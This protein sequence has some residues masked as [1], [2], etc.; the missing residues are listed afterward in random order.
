[1]R[2][3]LCIAALVVAVLA[4]ALPTHAGVRDLLKRG[5]KKEQEQIL[6]CIQRGAW[7]AYF[8]DDKG[9]LA[10]LRDTLNTAND[11]E[12]IGLR[13]T[14][15]EGPRIRLGVLKVINKSA[16]SEERGYAD[17]IEVPVAG[18]QE[19]LTAALYNTKRFDVIEQKRVEEILKQQTR[20][21]V[22]EPSP[23]AIVNVGKVLGA[24]YLVYGTVNEWNPGRGSTNLGKNLFQRGVVKAGKNDAE[25]A[26]TFTLTDVANGQN[27]FTTTERARMGEWSFGFGGLGGGEGA[28]QQTTPV[29][30]AIRACTNKAAFKIATFL[31]DRKWKGTVVDIKKAEI[32]VNAGSQQGMAPQSKLLVQTV[33]G[34]VKDHESGTI[35]GEDLKGIGTLEV[36]AVQ[37]AFSIAQ[38][39]EGCKGIKKGDR[40]ELATN[41]VPPKSIPECDVLDTSRLP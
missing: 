38:V 15:Y 10:P 30:Y 3:R 19:M 29:N 36:I 40:V 6:S 33:R 35:L 20:K 28:M 32:F 18:I 1:M 8:H 2:F 13:F 12:W 26:I 7:I 14:D 41:P 11:E 31:R 37:T 21:D 9:K 39:I 5:E 17:K 25:V 27:L 16:E 22:M 24:Q 23:S 34:V 4:L